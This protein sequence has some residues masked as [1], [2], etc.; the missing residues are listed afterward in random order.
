MSARSSLGEG[1]RR[2]LAGFAETLRGAGFAVGRAETL[3]AMRLVASP[4]AERP[5][6]L[7]A[8]LRAL[9]ASNRAEF[10]RFDEL[11]DAFWRGRGAKVASRAI[12][13]GAGGAASRRFES[14]PGGLGAASLPERAGAGGELDGAGQGRERGAL[15]A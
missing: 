3:D 14:G 4:A 6:R 5:E 7:R 1:A 2:R 10:Q 15:G 13:S 11:F 9:F 12:V 8:A